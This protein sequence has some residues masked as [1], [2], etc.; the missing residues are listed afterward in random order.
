MGHP[1]VDVVDNAECADFEAKIVALVSK[2][3][4]LVG[5]DVGDRLGTGAAK[6]KFVVRGP[7]PGEDAFPR[8]GI[9]WF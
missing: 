5:L 7:L 4:A 6:V 8:Y 3:A 1:Y 2:V 9:V